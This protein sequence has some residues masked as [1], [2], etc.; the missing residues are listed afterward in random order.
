MST[1]SKTQNEQLVPARTHQTGVCLLTEK[2]RD[3]QRSVKPLL[4]H[5]VIQ[6]CWKLAYSIFIQQLPLMSAEDKLWL[7]SAKEAST[8]VFSIPFNIFHH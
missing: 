2:G 3:T 8:V 4:K 5:T 7:I 1:L 6:T